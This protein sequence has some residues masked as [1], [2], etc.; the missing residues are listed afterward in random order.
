MILRVS[1]DEGMK[2]ALPPACGF[3]RDIW[4]QMKSGSF[5]HL[6]PNIYRVASV[7]TLHTLSLGK[8][9]EDLRCRNALW[10]R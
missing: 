6:A 5:I 1:F 10:F 8:E 3:P 2:G 4:G 7:N 9:R